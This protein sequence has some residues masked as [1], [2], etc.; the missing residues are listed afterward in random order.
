MSA[1]LKRA[2]ATRPRCQ[3]MHRHA[4]LAATCNP[5]TA[6]SATHRWFHPVASRM[7]LQF[8]RRMAVTN[9]TLPATPATLSGRSVLQKVMP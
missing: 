9:C 6:I 5:T 3:C 1:S 7:L 8:T 2:H 4:A